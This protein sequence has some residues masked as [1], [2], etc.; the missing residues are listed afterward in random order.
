AAATPLRDRLQQIGNMAKFETDRLSQTEG[1]T[2]RPEDAKIKQN[3]T[4]FFISLYNFASFVPRETATIQ[5]VTKDVALA[6]RSLQDAVGKAKGKVINAQFNEQDRQNVTARLDFDLRRA[7]E[8]ALDAELRKLGDVSS[9]NVTRASDS[10][11]VLDSKMR[12]LVSLVGQ[13]ALQP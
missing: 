8:P 11:N 2:G 13:S 9:R 10:D 4:Q 7:N 12:L 5:V 3:D 1:G 6:Y